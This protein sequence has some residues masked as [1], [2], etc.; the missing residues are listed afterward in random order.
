MKVGFTGTQK[1]MNLKQHILVQ[2]F[3]EEIRWP[4][5]FHHGDCIGADAQAHGIAREL[6]IRV[7]VHPPKNFEKRAFCKEAGMCNPKPYLERNRDIVNDTDVLIATPETSYEVVRSGTWATIRYARK[8]GKTVYV[9]FPDG[10]IMSN[11]P[12]PTDTADGT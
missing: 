8:T 3:L 5:E 11:A 2:T 6:G 4:S 1:G 12:L 7:I 10:T 9:F